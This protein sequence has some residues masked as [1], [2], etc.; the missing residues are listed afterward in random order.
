[1]SQAPPAGSNRS[2]SRDREELYELGYVILGGVFIAALVSCNLIF[3]KFFS[4]P[5]PGTGGF[6]FV[7]SVGIL[8][9]PLTFLVTDILSEVYGR[10]RANR[11]VIA[12][13]F[14]SLFVILVIAIADAAPAVQPG[15]E[16][17]G[18]SPVDDATFHRVFG[19]NWIAF[20]GSMGA[21]LAA[22]FVDIRIFHFW[23]RLTKGKHLWLRNNGSTFASQML[24][25]T[26]VVVL[27]VWLGSTFRPGDPG[28]IPWEAAPELILH[29]IVFKVLVALTDTPFFY[30]ATALARRLFP[31]QM[32]EAHASTPI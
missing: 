31:A 18:G 10:K 15:P 25:T 11:V 5:V 20:V 3:L 27:L 24:D 13:I 21:Y 19:L 8:P 4:L 14:A 22:Q 30:A 2:P 6:R 28:N 16:G 12:G 17:T 29:G 9:Y 7:Q 1:M 32:A 26:I 23:R